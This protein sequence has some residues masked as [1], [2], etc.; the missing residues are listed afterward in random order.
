MMRSTGRAW[1]MMRETRRAESGVEITQMSL[2]ASAH[3]LLSVARQM[4]RQRTPL[5][6]ARSI[7]SGCSPQMS[8]VSGLVRARSVKFW[9]RAMYSSPETLARRAVELVDQRTLQHAQQVEERH[10][11][12]AVL[13][14][15]LHVVAGYVAR[16]EHAEER[17]VLLDYR[18]HAGLARRAWCARPGP[19]A[20]SGRARGCGRSPRR[21]TCVRMFLMK[22]RGLHA[23]AREQARRL[24][25]YGAYAHRLVRAVAHGVL[26]AGVGQRG[27]DGICI[28]VAMPGDENIT[29]GLKVLREMG[30]KLY[31]PRPSRRGAVII[32]IPVK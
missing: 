25:V 3:S 15:G 14:D 10:V 7:I 1:Y 26:E 23:E 6:M 19:A 27:H 28:R 11:V 13:G 5:A 20:R 22:R 24:V 8:M 32:I 16:G 31:S 29:H 21:S 30:F 17:A 2:P 12:H 4:M 9:G 18:H